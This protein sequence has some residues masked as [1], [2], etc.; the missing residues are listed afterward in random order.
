MP[1]SPVPTSPPPPRIPAP[2]PPP[3]KDVANTEANIASASAGIANEVDDDELA[4]SPLRITTAHLPGAF[5]GLSY[6]IPL[7]AQGGMLPYQWSIE[8]GALPWGLSL[9][10]SHGVIR[11]EPESPGRFEI[12]LKVTDALRQ[13][14]LAPSLIEVSSSAGFRVPRPAGSRS[15]PLYLV[16]S[17]LPEGRIGEAYSMQLQALGGVRPYAWDLV[18]GDFHRGISL[19]SAMGLISGTPQE[20]G[21]RLLLIQVADSDGNQDSV[22]FPLRI[23]FPALTIVTQSLPRGELEKE[24]AAPLAVEGGVNPYRWSLSAGTLPPGVSLNPATGLLSG[25][26]TAEAGDYEV[27]LSATDK[28]GAQASRTFTLSI[29]PPSGFIVT[30]MAAAPSDGKVALTWVNPLHE[31]YSHTSIIRST[32]SFPMAPGEGTLLYSGTGSDFLD[33]NVENGT[34]YYYSAIPYMTTG[35][36]G[37]VGDEAKALV[38]P[39]AVTLTGPA[40]PF[41]DAVVSF[42]PLSPGG[43]GSASLS[44]ALGPPHGGGMLQG[45]MH[46]VS[47]HARAND[48]GGASPPYGGSIT[49]EFANNIVVDGEGPD[50]IVFEN[51]FY[52]NGD[53]EQR[54]ME[55]AIV[56]VSKDGSNFYTF[57]YDFVPH[58]TKSGEI[59][60]FNPYCYINA[61]GSSRGFAGITPTY[62][63][64]GSPDPR[65]PS[66]AGGDAFDLGAITSAKL[67]WIRYIRITATGDNWL[68]DVN[69]DRVRQACDS[70]ACSGEGKSGFDL[71]AVCAIHY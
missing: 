29:S 4:L 47:L 19:N 63:N 15:E 32:S 9:D 36:S 13:S 43:F 49:L 25:I 64:A 57:P 17:S 45:S 53:P 28:E 23:D 33:Q 39:Q 5:V 67:D 20:K 30:H 34:V 24:Y 1:S 10:S 18:D 35:T 44:W 65:I 14:D 60:C 68:M 59:N 61:D 56:A 55:P 40:D 71:D 38:M 7:F 42:Q 46:V 69:G 22:E 54:W 70:D 62:S 51:V 3:R 31:S 37:G 52:Q 58:Y 2:S 41:A 11:G 50:F 66:A 26:P 12:T 8:K 16:T 48:D 27:S 21:S 6:Y